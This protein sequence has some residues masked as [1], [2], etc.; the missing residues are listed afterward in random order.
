MPPPPLAC[1]RRAKGPTSKYINCEAFLDFSLEEGLKRDKWGRTNHFKSSWQHLT[2]V[3]QTIRRYWR[4]LLLVYVLEEKAAPKRALAP[5]S[6]QETF[7]HG[8]LLAL[9][10]LEIPTKHMIGEVNLPPDVGLN[11]AKVLIFAMDTTS[12]ALARILHLLS[13]YQDVQDKLCAELREA[14][15]K[16][17][18]FSLPL[19]T[20]IN[21]KGVNGEEMSEIF[22]PKDSRTGP[23]PI[24]SMRTVRAGR[25]I[26]LQTHATVGLSGKEKWVY[27]SLGPNLATST[28]SPPPDDDVP[29]TISLSLFASPVPFRNDCRALCPAASISAFA[30]EHGGHCV[31]RAHH[32][33]GDGADALSIRSAIAHGSGWR[34]DWWLCLRSGPAGAASLDVFP[35]II[36]LLSVLPPPPSSALRMFRVL[37]VPRPFRYN[38]TILL[39]VRLTPPSRLRVQVAPRFAPFGSFFVPA[40]IALSYFS[41]RGMGSEAMDTFIN[42]D[43]DPTQLVFVAA[44]AAAG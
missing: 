19:S 27:K 6:I 1:W 39:S 31:Q 37:S 2:S 34:R 25:Q 23:T 9:D 41:E 11:A 12:S 8:S 10:P 29:L 24:M 18:H 38:H 43:G 3:K 33:A 4:P 20:P 14:R 28:R 40:L 44:A 32:G 16:L 21:L 5:I 15:L 42:S 13:M 30:V 36:D 7:P 35:G 26:T 22:P 17:M